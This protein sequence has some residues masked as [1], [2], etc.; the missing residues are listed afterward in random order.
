MKLY[1]GQFSMFGAKAEIALREK[2][3]P[4][5]LEMVPF[6]FADWY[7][8]KH[9]EVLRV[10]PY[11]RQ[12]PI[13]I[14]G[15]VELFDSTLIFEYLEDLQPKPPLWPRDRRQRAQ[16]R[17]MELQSD[18]VFFARA[19]VRMKPRV[20]DEDHARAKQAKQ[21]MLSYYEVMDRHLADADYLAVSYSY[22][23]LTFFM[24]QFFAATLGVPVP[25]HCTRL[26]EWR[27]RVAA[28]PAVTAVTDRV[29][30]FFRDHA[31]L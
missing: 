8:P 28:R 5:E 7:E 29:S 14:D 6:T 12:V 1:S 26:L 10:N 20:N 15:E 3:I 22:A 18:E 13:L 31:T 30:A 9:P 27:A 19:I 17:R 25:S 21:D 23:D 2:G 16:A 11:K 24:A 4:F